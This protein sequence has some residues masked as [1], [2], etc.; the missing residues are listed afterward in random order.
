MPLL[1]YWNKHPHN[2]I[3]L[4]LRYINIWLLISA[5]LMFPSN[6]HIVNGLSLVGFSAVTFLV[7]AICSQRLRERLRGGLSIF[8]LLFIAM[9][10]VTTIAYFTVLPWYVVFYGFA[11]SLGLTTAWCEV[12]CLFLSNDATGHENRLNQLKN[13]NTLKVFGIAL[14]FFF[15]A[16]MAG[17][18]TDKVIS[19]V[20]TSLVFAMLIYYTRIWFRSDLNL[21]SH[22]H[23]DD[24][25]SLVTWKTLSMLTLFVFDLMV[26]TFWYI[27]L[28]Y[29]LI[30]K[31]FS[32]EQV[33]I[34]LSFQAF[35]HAISQQVWKYVVL[36]LAAL[37]VFSTSLL[38]HVLMVVVIANSDLQFFGMLWF[39][40]I[41]GLVNSGI[42]LSSSV[43]YYG[44]FKPSK[45]EHNLMHMGASHFG[46]FAG[47]ILWKIIA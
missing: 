10:L 24:M 29:V 27:Y 11:I 9:V 44:S 20:F 34:F 47:V 31:G 43:L 41:M 4:I 37:A 3:V 22:Y 28:P 17:T 18:A 16:L 40:G 45:I 5:P 26:F 8:L 12:M 1:K 21:L 39:F 36:K 6:I 2:I 33:A 13:Y 30:G 19:G 15:G 25:I 32:A 35:I 46:K 38:L 14:G 23:P 7:L 42:F